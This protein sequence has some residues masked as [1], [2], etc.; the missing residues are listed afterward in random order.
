MVVLLWLALVWL[1]WKKTGR[2]KK[3]RETDGGGGAREES[4]AARV[5][6]ER[7][8]GCWLYR[9][10]AGARWHGRRGRGR[11]QAREGGVL[12]YGEEA[13]D[14]AGLVGCSGWAKKER[15]RGKEREES[16]AS[17]Q[18]L[19]FLFWLFFSF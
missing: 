2:K 10:K 3:E 18:L 19:F 8:L 16:W 1:G 15:K 9:G 11:R 12:S 6:W 4:G 13:K 5:R 17:V 7:H 14:D